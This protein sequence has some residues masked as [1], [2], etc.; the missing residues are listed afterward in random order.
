MKNKLILLLAVLL[1]PFMAMAETGN[2]GILDVN[3]TPMLLSRTGNDLTLGTQG[4]STINFMRNSVLQMEMTGAGLDLPVS[5]HTLI[6]EDGTAASTCIGTGTFNG[7]TSVNIATTC[8]QT[9][10][11]VLITRNAAPSGT[12][13]CYTV[14]S[15]IVNAVSFEVDCNAAETGT[16]SWMI[17]KGQ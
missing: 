9:G 2:T 4:A 17:I 16:F 11:Y 8:I 14:A 13:I 6:L 3:G 7:T 12:A 1:V 10:D 5:G 15:G